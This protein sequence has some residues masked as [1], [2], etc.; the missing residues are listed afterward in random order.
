MLTLVHVTMGRSE[1]IS[2][3]KVAVGLQALWVSLT[4]EFRSIVAKLVP[5]AITSIDLLEGD[6]G[7]GSVFLF[8][9]SPHVAVK[10][11]KEKIVELDEST[12]KIALQVIEGGHLTHGYKFYKTGFK[13]TSIGETETLVDIF[14]T[15]EYD[16]KEAI[17]DPSHTLKFAEGFIYALEKYLHPAAIIA[18]PSALK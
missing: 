2:Q 8:N 3:V 6:G 18:N 4:G 12:H 15:Y 10:W 14:L 5:N 7:L 16:S 17:K 11:Q 13:F 9:F 1:Q